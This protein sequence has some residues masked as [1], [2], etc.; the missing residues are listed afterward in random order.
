MLFLIDG[1]N[2]IFNGRT[3]HKIALKNSSMARSI[4]IESL[5]NYC[6]SE[7]H[8]A[9]VVF[10]GGDSKHARFLSSTDGVRV[11]F[12]G[13]KADPMLIAMAPVLQLKHK[14]FIVVTSDNEIRGHCGPVSY[15]H[16]RAHET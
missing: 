11:Y 4:L 12:A 8:R 7:S 9:I 16:L 13:G 15:T 2:V 3:L 5:Q 1:Y 14:D 6:I 10:D